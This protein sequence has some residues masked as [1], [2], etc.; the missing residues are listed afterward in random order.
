MHKLEGGCHCGNIHMDV[1]LPRAPGE[2]RPRACDCDFCTK[3]AAAYLSDPQGS[4]SIHIGDAAKAARYRQG[5]GQA[6][7]LICTACGTLI[8]VSFA[9][10]GHLYGAA[11]AHAFEGGKPFGAEQPV[12]PRTL[13][14]GEKAKRWQDVWFP[15]VRITGL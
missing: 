14:A 1:A 12:S 7:F 13:S 6:E 15:D 5:S 4:F 10:G 2:Y 3:H 11:N 9:E 8:G